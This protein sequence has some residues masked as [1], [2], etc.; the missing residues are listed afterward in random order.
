MDLRD[1]SERRRRSARLCG[2]KMS[3][4]KT[5][6]D[7]SRNHLGSSG[8]NRTQS[9]TAEQRSRFRLRRLGMVFHDRPFSG[10][11]EG[12]VLLPCQRTARYSDLPADG[13][14]ERSLRQRQKASCSGRNL[15]RL[16][17]RPRC[18]DGLLKA[19]E[20]R[21]ALRVY[22]SSGAGGIDKLPVRLER[23][24]KN[25]DFLLPYEFRRSKYTNHFFWCW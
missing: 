5:A 2:W 25:L 17:R 7:H 1:R 8:R 11:S 24:G 15:Q 20:N 14:A 19:G 13:T 21:I 23:K 6:E 12:Q 22:N 10:S 3:E 9:R 4:G 16:S 18:A